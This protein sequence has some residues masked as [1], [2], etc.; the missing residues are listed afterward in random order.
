VGYV[1]EVRPGDLE[2]QVKVA[3][4]APLRRLPMVLILPPSSPLEAQ[5]P[6]VPAQ[7]NGGAP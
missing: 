7:K 2:L 4:A 3:L 6:L 5:A 1:A